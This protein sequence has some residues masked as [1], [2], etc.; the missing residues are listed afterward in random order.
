MVGGMFHSIQ[1]S[2]SSLP[3]AIAVSTIVHDQHE[4]LDAFRR[5]TPR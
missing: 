3:G 5:A 2:M 4:A 1:W